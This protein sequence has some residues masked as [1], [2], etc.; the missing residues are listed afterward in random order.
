LNDLA[1][2]H[3]DDYWFGKLRQYGDTFPYYWQT[4]AAVAFDEYADATGNT[5]YRERAKQMLMNNLCL[6]RADGSASCAYVYPIPA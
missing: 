3:W 2:R 5:A 1:I 6:F 4:I